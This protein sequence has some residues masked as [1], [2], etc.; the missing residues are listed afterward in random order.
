[1]SR[2]WEDEVVRDATQEEQESINA[3]IG[4]GINQPYELLQEVTITEPQYRAIQWSNTEGYDD[5]L[6][7]ITGVKSTAATLGIDFRFSKESAGRI[8]TN[9]SN[10]LSDTTG[11]D[12]I[13]EFTRYLPNK[14]RKEMR[15]P[16]QKFSEIISSGLSDDLTYDDKINSFV[17]RAQ[18]N[19]NMIAGNF[20]LYGRKKF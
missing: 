10:I 3:K 2:V 15:L 4:G 20:K 8:Y 17:V 9:E 13:I 19:N 6:L 16:D 18:N 5:L 1:M 11:K 12:F 7:V 14:M